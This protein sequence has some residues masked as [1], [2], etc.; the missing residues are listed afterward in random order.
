[1]P[2]IS[3]SFCQLAVP[4]VPALSAAGTYNLARGLPKPLACGCQ[5]TSHR[6][7]NISPRVPCGSNVSQSRRCR[8]VF[9][10]KIPPAPGAS[11]FDRPGVTGSICAYAIRRYKQRN[12]QDTS[13]TKPSTRLNAERQQAM[14]PVPHFVKCREPGRPSLHV[15]ATKSRCE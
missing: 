11:A 2:C 9:V 15:R 5:R 7:Q 12:D 1:M 4:N 14:A 3:N 10:M 8:P 13:I 6:A